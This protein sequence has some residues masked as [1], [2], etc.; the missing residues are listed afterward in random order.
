[1]LHTH[2]P[3]LFLT[4]EKEKD[5]APFPSRVMMNGSGF[6]FIQETV[7]TFINIHFFV[8]SGGTVKS[9]PGTFF[10]I[11]YASNASCESQ[12]C[13]IGHPTNRLPC[14]SAK[15]QTEFMTRIFFFSVIKCDDL[16]R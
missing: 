5:R 3:T 6:T 10:L 13:R 7:F 15:S 16:T 9:V 14:L 8:P 11:T 2:T 4:T 1:M 12:H